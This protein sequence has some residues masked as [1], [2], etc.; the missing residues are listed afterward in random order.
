MKNIFNKLYLD[1]IYLQSLEVCA[2]KEGF[3]NKR[4]DGDKLTSYSDYY[5]INRN[6]LKSKTLLMLTLFEEIDS[7]CTTLDFSSFVDEGLISNKSAIFNGFQRRDFQSPSLNNI[8]SNRLDDAF[9]F[10]E[11]A[12]LQILNRFKRE[13]IKDY[14]KKSGGDLPIG[15]D[16]KPQESKFYYKLSEISNKI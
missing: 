2:I 15:I 14:I 4:I 8:S 1:K 11:V 6:I 10:S 16:L 13:A 9:M 3:V 5:P 12:S 7:S